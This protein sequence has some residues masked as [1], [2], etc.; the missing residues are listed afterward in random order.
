[1]IIRIMTKRTATGN[2][3]YLIID[4]SK[5]TYSRESDRMIFDGMEVKTRDYNA[6]VQQC[7]NAGF[8]QIH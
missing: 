2:R 3:R 4:T 6:M 7:I 8:K 1:M 5:R